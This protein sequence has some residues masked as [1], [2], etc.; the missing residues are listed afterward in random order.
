M[1]IG[2]NQYRWLPRLETAVNDAKA[3]AQILR[4]HYSFKVT[5]LLNATRYDILSALNDLRE[6]LTDQDNLLIYYA[7]H[8]DLDRKNQRGHWLPVDAE[9]NSSANWISNTSITDILNTMS[10]RQLLLVVDSCYSG[11]L[12]RSAL[13]R[14]DPGISQEDRIKLMKAMARQRSRMVMTSGGLEPVLDSAGGEH[15]LFARRFIELLEGNVGLLSGRELFHLLQLRVASAAEQ[16]GIRQ[17][18]EYAPIKFAGHESG[19][20][21]FVRTDI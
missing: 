11:T 4:E 14:L 15:S 6:Q 13:G 20:F 10:V 18:P 7:G 5:L 2:N 8:G 19:G 21:I 17:V 12:T 9:P 3:V 1:V 16:K